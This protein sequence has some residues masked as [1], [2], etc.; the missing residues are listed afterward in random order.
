MSPE[1]FLWWGMGCEAPCWKEVAVESKDA[2]PSMGS[3]SGAEELAYR[4][5]LTG[6]YNRRFLRKSFEGFCAVSREQRSFL[7]LLFIDVDYFKSINDRYGHDQGDKVLV[8]VARAIQDYTPE[9]GLAIRYAGDEFMVVLPQGDGEAALAAGRRI[10]EGVRSQDIPLSTGEILHQTLSIGTATYPRDTEEPER[11][12]ELADE[13]V[14]ISKKKGRNCVS[15]L[16][17]RLPESLEPQ[18]LFKY[19]PC[20]K[21]V[22]RHELMASLKDFLSP[23]PG[24]M[25]PCILLQGERGIG[26]SRVLN[27]LASRVDVQRTHLLRARC[28]PV[29]AAQPFGELAEAVERLF[30]SDPERISALAGLEHVRLAALSPLIPALIRFG[31][32]SPGSVVAPAATTLVQAMGEVLAAL[33]AERPLVVILDDFQ[34]CNQGTRLALEAAHQGG[35]RDM[36]VFAS[37]VDD[38]DFAGRDA[39]GVAWLGRAEENGWLERR[40]LPCLTP[41]QVRE[42][43]DGILAT[44]GRSPALATLVEERSQGRPLL[45][46]GLVRYLIDLG[47]VQLRDGSLEID[48]P[49]PGELPA[50]LEQ[51][52]VPRVLELDY[53]VQRVLAK[54]S[55]VGQEFH[56]D[57]LSRLSGLSEAELH[58]VLQRAHKAALVD[59][60]SEEDEGLYAFHEESFRKSLYEELSPEERR[61]LHT[62][63]AHVLEQLSST[64]KDSYLSTLAHHWEG[65]R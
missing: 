46:E 12:K 34:W 18:R 44:L 65:R 32:V 52:L 43:L 57:V 4:D 62:A 33:A 50:D 14:F 29:S 51:I 47:R 59:V 9:G 36:A 31:L 45:V 22:G 3:S 63:T 60:R 21:L 30:E 27:E 6:L 13:A 37:F 58:D 10:L 23:A 17:E 48:V 26:R 38:S 15:T 24:K 1:W 7:S 41:S 61:E 64:N 2:R 11:L 20:R 55:V 54:A 16:D 39:E 49:A 19:F 25:R 56:V 40:D 35:A 28:R 5:E 42:M 8:T 53:E